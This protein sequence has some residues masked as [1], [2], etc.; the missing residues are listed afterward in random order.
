ML[1]FL[2]AD[3]VF[4]W[5]DPHF[6]HENIIRHCERPYGNSR[7]MEGDMVRRFNNIVPPDGITICVGDFGWMG[8]SHPSQ[9]RKVLR[10]LNGNHILV[11]GNHDDFHPRQY[12]RA[13]FQSVHTILIDEIYG[14]MVAIY[15]DPAVWNTIDFDCISIVGHVHNLFYL[16]SDKKM[17]NVGVDV[18]D[19]QPLKINDAI[20]ELK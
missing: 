12:I 3:K 13:G 19:F 20:E 6:G 11:M 4:V 5:A 18:N 8:W 14:R 7:H 10:K 15:H 1:R 16:Q 2:D 17:I 9:V